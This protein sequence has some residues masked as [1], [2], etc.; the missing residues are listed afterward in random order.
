MIELSE[1]TIGVWF[2]ALNDTTDFLGSIWRADGGELKLA[3]RFRYY[4]GDQS[5]EFEKSQDRK[6]WY[7][8][9]L[10]GETEEKAIAVM[11]LLVEKLWKD[12]GGQRYECLVDYHGF[13]DF[14]ERFKSMPF[15][16][17]KE[18]SQEELKAITGEKE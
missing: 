11:R 8:M 16:S 2:V 18:V 5:L 6:N 7:A 13:D 9:D 1:Q 10:K 4:E 17:F 14:V 15:T 3:Y 12:S